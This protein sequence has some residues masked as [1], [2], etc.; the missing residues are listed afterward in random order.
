MKTHDSISRR[1]FLALA[2]SA[3]LA[4][5]A[6]RG[7]SL[8]VGLELY[9]V[10][11]EL[12][13]DLMGTVRAVGK[14][15]YEGVEFYSPYF[16]W[17]PAYA[18]DVKK[19]LDD[20]GIRCFSTHNGA[21]SFTRQNLPRAIELNQRIGSK[22]IVMASAGEV[23][24]LDGWKRVADT[25][26]VAAEKA[27]SAGLSVGYHNHQLE[28]RSV[29]GRRPMEVIAG[30][31]PKEVMLQLDVGTCVEVGSDPVAWI[32]QNPGRIKSIHCKDWSRDP[33]V[34]YSVLLGE[35]AV[36]WKKVFQ[37]AE[38]AGGTEYYLIEQEGSAY[39]ELDTARR[40]LENYRKLRAS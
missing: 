3:P 19:L 2:A 8:P 1:S 11:G 21:E 10:R 37:A 29:E 34:S 18:R 23:K 25:L 27:K 17:T 13:N 6:Q 28:F 38:T 40:C 30:G 26:S 9:S 5:A 35:G 32:E 14:M 20:L 7:K 31:T 24:G 39:T 4:V 36:P 16:Q 22:F 12:A 15:G 33:A